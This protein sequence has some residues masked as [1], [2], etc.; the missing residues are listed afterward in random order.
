[1]PDP[2]QTRTF[3]AQAVPMFTLV[4]HAPKGAEKTDKPRR[5]RRLADLTIQEKTELV[6]KIIVRIKEL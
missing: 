2:K 4:T 6:D 1:M 3:E 5:A